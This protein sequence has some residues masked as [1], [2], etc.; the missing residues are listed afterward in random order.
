MSRIFVIGNSHL[1][2]LNN[3]NLITRFFIG[4]GSNYSLLDNSIDNIFLK[5][6]IL[7]EKNIF[8]DNDFIFLFFGECACRYS[9]INNNY[10]HKI[11]INKYKRTY[12][13]NMES[14][15]NKTI[16]NSIFNYIK[17]YNY[18]SSKHNN[19]YILSSTTSFFPI[20]N[21]VKY[22]NSVLHL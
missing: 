14:Y 9:L 6:D 1:R 8:N 11:P 17:L 12:K 3:N 7:F 16:E 2:S 20:I 21:K 4:P 5:I 10:P 13:K 15:T 18:I 19:T 22:F